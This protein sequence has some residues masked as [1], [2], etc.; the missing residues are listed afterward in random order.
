[1]F[2][3]LMVR[4]AVPPPLA[5]TLCWWGDQ[6]RA[7]TA[8]QC[9]GNRINSPFFFKLQTNNLLSFP[10]L[11]SNYSS[12]DH[13]KPQISC[14]CPWYF[15]TMVWSLNIASLKEGVLTSRT[16]IFLSLEPLPKR[17]PFQAKDPTLPPWPQTVLIS[18]YLAASYN[19]ISP[20]LLPTATWLPWWL[21]ATL[22]TMLL[23]SVNSHSLFTLLL[24]AD[25][26]Y[27]SF[28]NPTDI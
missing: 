5:R 14:L 9:Y 26:I 24:Q 20:K 2:Q 19:K 25:Q 4:S 23:F 27:T 8:A 18:F 28:S 3:N 11:P 15:C 21:H 13:F 10:P 16:K 22:H 1:M 7:F 6:A 17:Y 12:K